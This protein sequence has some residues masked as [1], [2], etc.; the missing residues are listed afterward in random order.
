MNQKIIMDRLFHGDQIDSQQD[1]LSESLKVHIKCL[2]LTGRM[3][4]VTGS[5]EVKT[6]LRE[7]KV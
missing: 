7:R 4:A 5:R 6:G 1:S 2:R 3:F